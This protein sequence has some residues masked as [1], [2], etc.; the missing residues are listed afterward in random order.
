M[1]GKTR[2]K[3]KFLNGEWCEVKTYY[4]DR[5]GVTGWAEVTQEEYEKEFPSKPIGDFVGNWKNA[6]ISDTLAVHPNQIKEASD[7]AKKLGVPTEFLPDGRPIIR[8][9]AHQREYAKKHG[10]ICRNSFY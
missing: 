10:F 9:T 4:L 8:S 3:T 2:T 1:R 6:V 5:G 7:L